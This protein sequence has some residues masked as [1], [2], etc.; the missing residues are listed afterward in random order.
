MRYRM[1]FIPL[2]YWSG[3]PGSGL[4]AP[5]ADDTARLSALRLAGKPVKS[6][7]SLPCAGIGRVLE[8]TPAPLAAPT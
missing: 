3:G 6:F 7:G 4:W 2:S 5:V 8:K 1:R